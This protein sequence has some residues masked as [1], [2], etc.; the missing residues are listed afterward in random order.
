[1]DEIKKHDILVLLVY[2]FNFIMVFSLKKNYN[3]NYS[4]CHI[5]TKENQIE[6][7]ILLLLLGYSIF[8]YEL[9]RH[10]KGSMMTMSAIFI[11]LFGIVLFVGND[12]IH[13]I[14][15][16]IVFALILLFM[17]LNY[18]RKK[19]KYLALSFIMELFLMGFIV[20]R[21]ILNKTIIDVETIYLLNLLVF[22][23]ILHYLDFY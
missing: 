2:F 3:N 12:N 14:L 16:F 21:L 10:D 5:V 4:L 20:I 6:I 11:C 15:S 22:H 1:M 13:K 8:R 7:F 9:I 23:I 19:N 17:Y 18:R